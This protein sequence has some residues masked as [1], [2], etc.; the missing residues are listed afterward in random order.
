MNNFDINNVKELKDFLYFGT[1]GHDAKI[2][3]FNYNI[4]ENNIKIEL[5][6][7]Y[8][9]KHVAII[10]KGIELVLKI[11]GKERWDFEAPETVNTLLVQDTFSDLCEYLPN[12]SGEF[13]GLL[14]LMFEMFSLE[15]IYIVAKEVNIVV[16]EQA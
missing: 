11:N 14:C 4:A 9:K 1:W 15:R 7:P 5:L 12:Y 8:V 6:N 2:K 10:F 3:S 16:T 13:N